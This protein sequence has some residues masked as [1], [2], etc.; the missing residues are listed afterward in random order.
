MIQLLNHEKTCRKFKC[1]LVSER[2]QCERA[3]CCIII[4][5]IVVVTVQLL[6]C[7]WLFETPLTVTHQAPLSSTVSWCCVLSCFSCVRLFAALWIIAC[8]APLF[9]GFSRQEC[10]SGLP[11]PPPGNHPNPGIKPVSLTSPVLAGGF[12]TTSTILSPEVCSDS[13]PL[14]RWRYL[15]ISSS[16]VPF[17]CLHS[18]HGI[19]QARILEWVAIF[20]FSGPRFIRTLHYDPSVLGGPAGHGSLSFASPFATARL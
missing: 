14:S 17:F 10:W 19:L 1:V 15:S 18:V 9:K 20:F 2:S 7:V 12:F 16:A 3:T 5:G 6:S 4:N 11:F 13:C 8:Q